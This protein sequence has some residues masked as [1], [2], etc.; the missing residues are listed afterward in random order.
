MTI[1]ELSADGILPAGIHDCTVE[2]IATTFGAFQE[3]DQRPQL[4]KRLREFLESVKQSELAS[5]VI[6]D[7]SFVTSKAKPSDVDMVLVLKEEHDFA[8]DLRPFQYNVLSSR[9]V[10]KKYSFDL[11]VAGENSDTYT[12]YVKYFQQVKGQPE[13]TKGV[14]RV[15]L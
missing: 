8:A 5:S 11:L 6:V 13:K 10:R 12:E 2:D 15:T 7:G 9:N 1:P 4:L 3:S 14:L